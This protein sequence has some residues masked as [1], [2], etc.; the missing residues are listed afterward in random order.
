MMKGYVLPSMGLIVLGL[1]STLYGQEPDRSAPP[2]LGPPPALELPAI[3]RL[4]LSNGTPVLLL[5]KHNVP[6][7][8]INLV[9]RAGSA[10][11]SQGAAGTASMTA[12]MM[13]EGAAGR[14]ALELADEI[15]FLGAR[16]SVFSGTH[17]TT[18]ALHT[19]VSRLDAA[20]GLMADVAL[21]PDFPEEELE[22]KRLER[23]TQLV[24][25]RDE[26]RA[27]AAALFDRT[28]Y[29]E[30]HPYGRTPDEASL[31]AM[32]AADLRD[33]HRT[34]FRPNNAFFV[35]VGDVTMGEIKPKLEALFGSW[36]SG[37]QPVPSWPKVEQVG[38]REVFLVDKPGAAQS[39][40]RIGRIGVPRLTED[41]Y[42]IVV[43]N[44]IL[45]G[46]FASRLN[47]N[48]RE[49]HGYTYGARSFFSF[50]PL[51]G[52]FQA[53]A[54]V[55]TAVTDKALVEFMKE[56]RGILEP[57]NED[58][59][60]RAKNFVAL[61]FPSRFQTVS[62]I[63]GQLA[64]LELYDLPDGYFNEYVRRLLAVTREDVQRVAR[65]YLDPERLSIVVVGDRQTIEDGVRA[66]DLGRLHLLSVT[67]VLGEAPV[68]SGAE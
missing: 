52:P 59:L 4:Q 45:G 46:S 11:D 6:L 5:E 64:E 33:F 17:N 51:P 57:V 10:L 58:E 29:G 12:D 43:M 2:E 16:I 61:R 23:L 65:E 25:A 20:L 50:R 67:D 7:A 1:A 34:Y 15:D 55:Q 53:G 48:L 56:L 63:A 30:E 19:P 26:P 13:D 39:E 40:I 41:Y 9:V 22:R 27:I 62:G 3:Q 42:A 49:E 54:A 38:Q 44:T 24:Q 28:L 21:R 68:L 14:N 35:V 18:L 32:R 36:E 47:Q 8:Q 31:R 37:Q 66:L 60:N